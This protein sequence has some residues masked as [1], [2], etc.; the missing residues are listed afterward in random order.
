L[1]GRSQHP[2]TPRLPFLAPVSPAGASLFSN[3]APRLGK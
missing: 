2:P 1:D 3:L